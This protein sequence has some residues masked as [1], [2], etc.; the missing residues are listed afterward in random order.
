LPRERFPSFREAKRTVHRDGHV[1]VEKSYYSVPPEYVGREVWARWDGRIVRIFNHRLE[2]IRVH[3]RQTPG[4]FRT[5]DDDLHPHKINGIERGTAWLLGKAA[6]IGQQARAWAEAMLQARGIEGVRVLQGL[7]SLGKRYPAE[8]LEQACRTALSYRAFRL[9]TL[10]QLLK[11]GGAP[12]QP[13]P[14]LDEHPIIRPL[15]DYAGW[16]QAALTRPGGR[17]QQDPQ[18]PSPEPPSSFPSSLLPLLSSGEPS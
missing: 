11:H 17:N 3:L 5:S 6:C 8:A 14:F 10:R 2:Q 4:K 1:E 9:R 15:A 16:L 13:L 12:Q 7:L 18:V